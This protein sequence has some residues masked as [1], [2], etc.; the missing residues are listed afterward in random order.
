MTDPATCNVADQEGDPHSVLELCRR[1]IAARR[2]SADLAV[3]A[4]RSLPSPAGTW[5]YARGGGGGDPRTIV[6]LNMS[7]DTVSFD[8]VAGT[9]AVST[10]HG[11]EG[12]SIEGAL[13][14]PPWGGAV[15]TR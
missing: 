12:S 11:L 7:S 9:V 15:V 8:D 13:A 2:E 1:A 5:A 6:L 10:E 14:L 3:G 4:Y